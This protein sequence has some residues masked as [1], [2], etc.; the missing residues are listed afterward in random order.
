MLVAS[1]NRHARDGARRGGVVAVVASAIAVLA[2]CGGSSQD[3]T[4]AQAAETASTATTASATA[5]GVADAASAAG[6]STPDATAE[7]LQAEDA[8]RRSGSADDTRTS[9]PNLLPAVNESGIAATFSL[10]GVIDRTGPFF[11]SL[12]VN[13]RSCATCHVQSEG[14]TI[15]P[16]GVQ[17][18][19]ARTR[20][21]DPIFRTNDGSN[22]PTADVSS[23][24]AR[25]SAYSML[26]RKGLIRVGLPIP[27]NAEFELAAVDD[28]Y[29]FASAQELSL[30]RRPLPT[31][32][33]KFLST[34]MWDG[35]E[36]FKDPTSTDCTPNT[37][38][39]FASLHFDLSD[40]ANSATT[41]H[42][43]AT[44]A[45][46]Q[47]QREAIVAFESDLF[48]A[49]VFDWRAGSLTARGA[50]GG[51]VELSRE[52][53][54]FGINDTLAG[55]YRTQAPFT[56]TVMTLYDAWASDPRASGRRD[57]DF[58]DR[59]ANGGQRAVARGQALFN[60]KPIRI[61]G[62]KGLNDDLH[63]ETI[64]GT[65][66]TCHNTP[67]AGDHSVPLPLDLG[68]TDAARRT[69]DMPLYTLR[70]KATGATTQTTDPGRAL[71]TGKWN[72]IG[73][74]KG[75]VLRALATRAP[76][77]HNGM[78]KDLN[79]AVDFYDT[80]FGIG[81]TAAEKA[82]LVAFLRTL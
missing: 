32:N 81:F 1:K 39:C 17:E 77:F 48:L 9:L 15:T 42:A 74:F 31:A 46:S 69:P 67:N 44:S 30:F 24:A 60:G 76:Y 53:F 36:T 68:L 61:R 79:E 3:E 51:P 23:V 54:H 78:A 56:P 45:L 27:A 7:R 66:T 50:R 80:R 72:D 14:W 19:F 71:V 52:G 26:L 20:G 43:Q 4:A 82:D 10:A 75:P 57:D 6:A 29:R 37:S 18:R 21:L 11:Q 5:A 8:D 41:G 2:A 38:N 40:Q 33:L 70:N 63:V 22:A 58:R 28:P 34:L 47:A 64:P 62:V 16:A 25:R 73:R 55:D 35:R 13:G 12:G 65:C 49:Q 59:G